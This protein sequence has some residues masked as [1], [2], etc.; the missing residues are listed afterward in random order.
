MYR[1]HRTK[2][3]FSMHLEKC[4]EGAFSMMSVC[5]FLADCILKHCRIA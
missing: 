5:I 2:N 3:D 4:A 1:L